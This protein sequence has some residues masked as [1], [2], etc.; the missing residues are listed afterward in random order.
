MPAQA[1]CYHTTVTPFLL[2]FQIAGALFSRRGQGFEEL[3]KCRLLSRA[4]AVVCHCYVDATQLR[5]SFVLGDS[6]LS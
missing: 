5:A 4:I 6:L 1:N 3:I 2:A